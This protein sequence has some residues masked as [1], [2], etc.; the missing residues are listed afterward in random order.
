MTE[1]PTYADVMTLLSDNSL[2]VIGEDLFGGEWGTKT[3]NT[4]IDEQVL[5]IEGV[6]TPSELK[7]LYEQ[8]SVQILVRGPKAG[9][10]IDVYQRAKRISNFLLSQSEC[11][12][13][14]G[15]IYK[16]FEEGSNLAA[17]G[18][19]ENQRFIYSMNFFTF[20]NR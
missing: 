2:G 8:P 19:D 20:R 7:D 11:T 6:G 13:I 12:E 18:K 14:N 15:K 17:L 3:L 16:G 5:V 10:D 4:D 1:T 9:A